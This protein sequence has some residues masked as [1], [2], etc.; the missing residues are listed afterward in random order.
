MQLIL[1]RYGGIINGLLIWLALMQFRI[2][3]ENIEGNFILQF[4]V[5]GTFFM[6]MGVWYSF[7]L[8][9]FVLKRYTEKTP[10]FQKYEEGIDTARRKYWLFANTFALACYISIFLS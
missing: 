8:K 9:R 7:F 3:T 2:H 10:E 1:E 4:T 6:L 5:Y